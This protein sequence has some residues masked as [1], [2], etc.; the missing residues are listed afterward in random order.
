MTTSER[1]IQTWDGTD[2][3][4]HSAHQ[5]AWGTDILT[6]LPL[7]GDERI[8]DLGCG[9]GGVTRRLAAR[10]PRGSVLG[11]DAAAGML[12]AARQQP[13]PNTAYAEL[14]IDA[15][16]FEAEFDL[17]Y[18]NA[19]LHWVLDH[20]RFL[21]NAHRALRPGGILRVQFGGAGNIP[22]LLD[23]LGRQMA[24]PPFPEAFARFRWPWFF[25]DV[26]AYESLL[27]AAPFPEWRAWLEEKVQRFPAADALVGWID[28]PCL[29]P[30]V[31]ALPEELRRPFRDGVVQAMR[32]RTGQPDG[33]H[34]EPFSRMNVWAR[35]SA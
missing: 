23:C 31:Q 26:A 30:F 20:S 24:L 32:A 19:A 6:E 5:R 13:L 11:I 12:E 25:P 3:A 29:I 16:D 27:Q 18:S 9:D 8:L 22:N 34:V 14:D 1:L 28:N 15:L 35:R 21:A 33:S 10:V 4:R 17:I 7:R 2:Y